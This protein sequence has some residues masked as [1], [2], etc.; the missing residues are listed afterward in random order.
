MTIDSDSDSTRPASIGE[1]DGA[2][3]GRRPAQAELAGDVQR[4]QRA[5]FVARAAADRDRPAP[6]LQESSWS[7]L[8][9]AASAAPRDD[10]LAAIAHELRNALGALRNAT[11]VLYAQHAAGT[12]IEGARRLMERQVAQMARRI[13]DMFEASRSRDGALCLRREQ[14]DLRLP[15][16]HAIEDVE[17]TLQRRGQRLEVTLPER[18]VALY[19][20]PGRL[21]QVFVNL[22]G[23]A[24]KYTP[25]GGAI[26]VVV[27]PAADCACVRVRDSG[28]GISPEMLA[29]LFEPR[30]QAAAPVVPCAPGLGIGLAL[31]RAL[32]QLHGGQVSA[33][34]GGIGRGSE[35]TVTLP[36]AKA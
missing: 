4:I 11:E 14:L 23:N 29:R 3:P 24:S 20:D 5:T 32:I 16:T 36:V 18:P 10:Q 27:E 25:E 13:D 26:A 15:V 35:F 30:V 33:A 12:S 17:P 7:L 1:G 6:L 2:A 28:I 9:P 22:L 34:S 31:V 21:E 19:A 8:P